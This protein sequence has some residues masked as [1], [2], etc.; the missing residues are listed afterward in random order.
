M[1]TYNFQRCNVL[2][3]EDNEYILKLFKNLLKSFKFGNVVTTS[4][5]EEAIT[6]LKSLKLQLLPIQLAIGALITVHYMLQKS[7]AQCAQERLLIQG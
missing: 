6:Y 1:V 3:V 7:L 2:L 5:G 4:N